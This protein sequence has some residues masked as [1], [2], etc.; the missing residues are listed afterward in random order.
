MCTYVSGSSAMIP[1]IVP[2]I[3]VRAYQRAYRLCTRTAVLIRSTRNTCTAVLVHVMVVVFAEN[4]GVC[5]IATKTT[6]VHV[7]VDGADEME[8]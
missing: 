6:T 5:V 7:A 8:V 1:G 4:D 2:M 3:Q